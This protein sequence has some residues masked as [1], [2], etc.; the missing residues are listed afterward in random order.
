MNF[1]ICR[2]MNKPKAVTMG[3]QTSVKRQRKNIDCKRKYKVYSNAFQRY[4]RKF[5]KEFLPCN[6]TVKKFVEKTPF[7]Y[8]TS[9]CN[10]LLQLWSTTTYLWLGV[11]ISKANAV[12]V[13]RWFSSQTIE[14][15][16]LETAAAFTVCF[17]RTT[18]LHTD[19]QQSK[20]H[21]FS[22]ET[23]VKIKWSVP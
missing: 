2:K 22:P 19:V 5:K 12:E 7:S 4:R 17:A 1:D 14:M 13:G 23:P 10:S 8:L 3:Q 20:K 15:F 21:L 6:S 18:M 16:S 11:G 9:N